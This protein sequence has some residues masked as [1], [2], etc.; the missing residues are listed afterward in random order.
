MPVTSLNYVGIPHITSPD[1]DRI[2]L[3]CHVSSVVLFSDTNNKEVEVSWQNTTDW[4]RVQRTV[5]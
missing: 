2:I 5:L 4:C 3:V 1:N